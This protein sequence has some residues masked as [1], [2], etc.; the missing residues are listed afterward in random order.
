MSGADRVQT[1]GIIGAGAY[2]AAL[3]LAAVGAG[4]DVLIWAR[5]D[6]AVEAIRLTRQA[7]RLPGVTLPER[8]SAT[9]S[10]ADLVAADALLLTVPTQSLRQACEAL[11]SRLPA[12]RPVISAAKG[13]EQR[14]GLF[15]TQIIAQALPGA[16]PAILSGPSFAADIGKGLPTAVTLAA[17]D[18]ALAQALAEALSSPAFRIYHS[19]DPRGVEIGGAAKNVLAI[20]AGI[21]I[22]LGYGES[23][24]AALVARGFA[25]LRRFGQAH[26]AQS[27]TL[28]GLSGLGDVVLSCASPQSRNFAFGLALGQGRSVTDAAGGA[29][30][31]GAFTAQILAQM[32]RAGG[33]DM[34]IAD[35]VAG[36]IDGE[37]GVREAVTGLL[38]RPLR[39]ERERE[40][41]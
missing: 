35:A 23:A 14:T 34:P 16:R 29:L 8:V 17:T 36:I 26:G 27:E 4:R 7:P 20:A 37:I 38:A 13:I 19:A 30:A 24:R 10:L 41:G 15:T 5:D 40:S 32:A 3:A 31:E 11:A 12:D 2:G 9:A 21:A 28:M 18:A 33:V 6:A 1:I 25:E 39:A 22:G